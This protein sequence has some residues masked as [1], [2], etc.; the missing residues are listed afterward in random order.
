MNIRTAIPI[1]TTII[2]K[3]LFVIQLQISLERHMIPSVSP[4]STVII[5]FTM[6]RDL[7]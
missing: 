3:V 7:F 6:I 4:I 2:A 1:A 5:A